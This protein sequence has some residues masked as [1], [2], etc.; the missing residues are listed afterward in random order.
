MPIPVA[1]G[2]V[3]GHVLFKK[4]NLFVKLKN[5]TILVTFSHTR[6]LQD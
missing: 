1:I 4:P 2:P 3:V 6:L 5:S